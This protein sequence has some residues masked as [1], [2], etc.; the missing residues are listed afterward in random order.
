MITIEEFKHYL[1]IPDVIPEDETVFIKDCIYAAVG[2]MN[3][4]TNRV[5]VQ[6]DSDLTI[7]LTEMTEYYDGYD[8]NILYLNNHP[9]INFGTGTNELMYLENDTEWKNILNP[10]DTIADSVLV[11][12]YGKLVLQK[13]Y[14]FPE[15]VKN[16]KVKYKSG[17]TAETLPPDL[18]RICYEFAAYKFFNS[19]YAETSRL[20]IEFRDD[21][22]GN[23]V[24]YMR[25]ET[26]GALRRYRRRVV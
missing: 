6:L 1:K 8:T 12:A 7:S 4:F 16:I 20:G 3:I 19:N 2:E 25:R 5:L 10:P 15:G 9:L 14:I 26:E 23:R 21:S 11:L 22:S 17:Y 24:R 13:G 18:K